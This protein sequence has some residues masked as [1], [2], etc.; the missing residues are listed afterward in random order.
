[1]PRRGLV[2]PPDEDPTCHFTQ[3]KTTSAVGA[4]RQTS[5]LEQFLYD[6]KSIC[7][8]TYCWLKPL[9]FVNTVKWKREWAS[10][11]PSNTCNVGTIVNHPLTSHQQ[12]VHRG[13]VPALATLAKCSYQ[14][15]PKRSLEV[16]KLSLAEV[17]CHLCLARVWIIVSS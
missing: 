6:K 2:P 16:I 12:R 17:C 7:Q 14:E 8:Q 13:I 11:T 10:A 15:G 9:T 1:M 3:H 4:P 5:I